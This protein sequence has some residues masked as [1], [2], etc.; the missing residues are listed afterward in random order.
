MKRRRRKKHVGTVLRKNEG[1][2]DGQS[3]EGKHTRPS[4]RPRDRDIREHRP[5]AALDVLSTACTSTE[6]SKRA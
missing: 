6:R 2:A 3:S 4:T 1:V 5:D